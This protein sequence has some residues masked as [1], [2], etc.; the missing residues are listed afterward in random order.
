MPVTTCLCTRAS[1]CQFLATLNNLGI[2]RYVAVPC[3]NG[4][5]IELCHYSVHS[6]PV[7]LAVKGG[8]HTCIKCHINICYIFTG[9]IKPRPS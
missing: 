9:L 7:S 4:T 2:Y 3:R 5:L 8:T 6:S 1:L